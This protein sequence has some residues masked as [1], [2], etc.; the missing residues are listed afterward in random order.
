MKDGICQLD[1]LKT[2]HL[3]HAIGGHSRALVLSLV[4]KRV[5]QHGAPLQ[6]I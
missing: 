4:A 3:Q 5:L 6:G 1:S 2:F